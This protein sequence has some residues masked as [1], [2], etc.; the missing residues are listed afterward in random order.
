MIFAANSR[1]LNLPT[2]KLELPDGTQIVYLRRRFVPPPEV[3]AL[4]GE[5][6]VVER[7]RIDLIAA[8]QIGDSE[9]FWQICDA[10]RAMQ[11][12]ALT[13]LVGRRLRIAQ[14]LGIPGMSLV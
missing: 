1:Y 7:D 9:M 10:N 2:T 14:P 12:A 13:E 3:F 11:P 8:T 6:V 4:R 5:Y